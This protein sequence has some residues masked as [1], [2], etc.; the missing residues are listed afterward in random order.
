[1]QSD[2]H[3]ADRFTHTL[4][5]F[6]LLIHQ[7]KKNRQRTT[8]HSDGIFLFLFFLI[9]G[10]SPALLTSVCMNFAVNSLLFGVT[11]GQLHSNEYLHVFLPGLQ[12]KIS[13]RR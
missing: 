11:L 6:L 1:M 5:Y 12:C 10:M 3:P 2:H 13:F 8:L 7:R 9:Y 4:C